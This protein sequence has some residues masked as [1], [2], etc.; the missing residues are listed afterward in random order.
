MTKLTASCQI[1]AFGINMKERGVYQTILSEFL[2]VVN[3][4]CISALQL[5]P[6]GWPVKCKI[7]VN[8]ERMKNEIVS[9]GL[10]LFEK[11]IDF[12]DDNDLLIKLIIK[13]GHPEW[14][15]EIFELNM[16]EYAT[17]VLVEKEWLYLRGR[18]TKIATGTRYVYATQVNK[19]IPQKMQ[20]KIDDRNFNVTAWCPHAANKPANHEPTRTGKSCIHCGAEHPTEECPHKKKV[21][22]ICQGSDHTQRECPRN[23]GVRYDDKTLIFFNSK[24]PLSSWNTEYPFKVDR[25][26]YLCI[27]QFLTV[28]K[29]YHFGNSSIAQEAMNCL[30]PKK[31]RELGENIPNFNLREWN[32]VF[33][34]IMKKALFFKFSDPSARGAR[35]YLLSTKDRIIGESSRHNYWGTGLVASAPNSLD[36]TEWTG[37]NMHGVYLMAIRDQI[38]EEIKQAKS[39]A[40]TTTE[41]TGSKTESCSGNASPSSD[42]S[43]ISPESSTNS[44]F[45]ENQ[46][47]TPNTYAVVF[48]DGNVPKS[49]VDESELPLTVVNLSKGEMK[50]N[51]VKE[52]ANTCMIPKDDID[53]VVF[54]LGACHWNEDEPVSEA[55]SVY[56]ELENAVTYVLDVYPKAEFVVSGV[57]LR[58][59]EFSTENSEKLKEINTEIMKFNGMLASFARAERTVTFCDNKNIRITETL[60]QGHL[61]NYENSNQLNEEGRNLLLMNL[62]IAISEAIKIN[63]MTGSAW[64]KPRRSRKKSVA[65][66]N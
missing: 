62:K 37:S 42:A 4:E 19:Y 26:E 1:A 9:R 21:C 29:A 39:T 59:P 65:A 66:K 57:P 36:P 60:E 43:H 24:C 28:E 53:F 13:D 8:E 52:A 18:R 32:S 25:L 23:R 12:E 64:Q 3:E 31:I 6:D 49:I 44:S 20:F 17:V 61:N 55:E 2:K 46:M 16:S 47:K 48:G 41:K 54:H 35:D 34:E 14:D 33:D 15:D 38:Q 10:D 30:D 27:E 7:T 50:F 58:D 40:K 11:H 5:I 63:L 45:D 51:D 56:N 22:Y